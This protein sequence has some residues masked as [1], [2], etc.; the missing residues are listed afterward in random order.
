MRVEMLSDMSCFTCCQAHR[1]RAL[2]ED[3]KNVPRLL[4]FWGGFHVCSHLALCLENAL[5]ILFM[6][7]KKQP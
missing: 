5:L 2:A 6:F 1:I 3:N 7:I 4:P